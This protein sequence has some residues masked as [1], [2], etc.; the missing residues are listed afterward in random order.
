[1]AAEIAELATVLRADPPLGALARDGNLDSIRALSP[2]TAAALD[3]AVARIGHRGP[4][5]AEL[6]STV[7]FD[8]PATLLA[9][10]AEAALTPAEPT[11]PATLARRLA[12]NTRQSRELAHDTTIRFTH[13]LRTTLRELGPRRVAADL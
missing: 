7:F 8:D 13:E 12:D 6:A 1:V 10:A 3:A 2:T 4:G 9:A 11:P 5:E